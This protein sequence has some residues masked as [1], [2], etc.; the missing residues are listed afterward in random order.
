MCNETKPADQF[1][2]KK[3]STDGLHSYC[4][5]CYTKRERNRKQSLRVQ[6]P[7][8]T[9]KVL[10]PGVREQ[11]VP[12]CTCAACI[13]VMQLHGLIESF[14]LRADMCPVP[15]GE[16]RRRFSGEPLLRRWADAL[17]PHLQD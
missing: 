15:R 7:T 16:A 10:D 11:F 2:L 6:G 9:E 1:P 4:K 8:V 5:P 17:L 14:A 3:M 12:Q 13:P